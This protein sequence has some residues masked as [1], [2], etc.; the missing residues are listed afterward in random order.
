[1]NSNTKVTVVNCWKLITIYYVLLI[2]Q[3]QI[4]APHS[5]SELWTPVVFSPK[6]WERCDLQNNSRS[7]WM[8]TVL[9]WPRRRWWRS[10]PACRAPASVWPPSRCRRR[11]SASPEARSRPGGCWR[12]GS[13]PRRSPPGTCRGPR[14]RGWC[15]PGPG[16]RGCYPR[17]RRRGPG[18]ETWEVIIWRPGLVNNEGILP[19]ALRHLTSGGHSDNS[20][21]EMKW[22]FTKRFFISEMWKEEIT[23]KKRIWT[24]PR[25]SSQ[26]N[27]KTS[28]K[29]WTLREFEVG[30]KI[31]LY[32]LCHKCKLVSRNH[33]WTRAPVS[34]CR[35]P[36]AKWDYKAAPRCSGQHSSPRLSS[37]K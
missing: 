2:M 21:L 12:S 11:F 35:R 25:P 22:L 31:G 19:R 28:H 32:L 8:R 37:L 15:C 3:H 18:H 23:I 5:S 13:G 4:A 10:P 30:F 34:L 33:S 36:R 17:G 26:Q 27:Q 9:Y 24:E 14:H 1:M 7:C 29:L 20:F 6:I 16:G